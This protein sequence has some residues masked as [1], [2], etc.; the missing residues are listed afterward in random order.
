MKFEELTKDEVQ[1]ISDLYWN[2]DLSWDTRMKQLSEYIGKSE[3]TVQKW[4]AKLGITESAVQESP[5]LIKA[6]ERK[7]NKK[8]KRFIITWAQNNTPVHEVFFTN[9]IEYANFINA[10]IH[11][12]AGRYKNP[13]SVF[14]S[15]STLSC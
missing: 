15:I 9:L 5:Q 13:T 7:F 4:L 11:V 12:I 10:D 6:R 14:T 1:S 8:K 2:K 3:R